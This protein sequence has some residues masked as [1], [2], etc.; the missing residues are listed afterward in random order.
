MQFFSPNAILE[1]CN[2]INNCTPKCLTSVRHQNDLG[3]SVIITSVWWD[4]WPS[5]NSGL[6]QGNKD[7]HRLHPQ[8]LCSLTISQGR[9]TTKTE[10]GWWN[11]FSRTREHHNHPQTIRTVI[12]SAPYRYRSFSRGRTHMDLDRTPVV[13]VKRIS[14][15]PPHFLNFKRGSIGSVSFSDAM[16][17]ESLDSGWTCYSLSRV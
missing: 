17:L 5:Q 11:I 16:C 15:Y 6:V 3:R 7:E 12:A 2:L 9:V 10:Y 14:D 1:G 4:E 8:G 13:W